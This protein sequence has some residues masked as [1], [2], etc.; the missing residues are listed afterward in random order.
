MSSGRSGKNAGSPGTADRDRAAWGVRVR[1]VP[2][3]QPGDK[4]DLVR[5]LVGRR[6]LLDQVGEPLQPLL[7]RQRRLHEASGVREEGHAR[8]LLLGDRPRGP[9]GD[10]QPARSSA[11]AQSA[12]TA[13]R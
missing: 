11:C 12:A 6:G 4:G 3:L 8:E 10:E 7:H 9:L 2:L 5:V 13:W 1:R